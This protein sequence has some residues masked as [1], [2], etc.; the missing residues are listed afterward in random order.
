MS[1]TRR[2]AVPSRSPVA[3]DPPSTVALD[4]E[5]VLD[6]ELSLV[7]KVLLVLVLALV[8]VVLKVVVPRPPTSACYVWRAWSTMKATGSLMLMGMRVVLGC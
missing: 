6:L 5:L 3:R 1:T 7:L 8:L 4:L 2:I